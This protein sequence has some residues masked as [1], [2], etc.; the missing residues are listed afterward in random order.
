M[1]AQDKANFCNLESASVAKTGTHPKCFSNVYAY[2]MVGNV[3]E[4]VADWAP[5]ATTG[6]H[7]GVFGISGFGDDVSNMG[8]APPPPSDPSFKFYGLPGATLRGGSFAINSNSGGTGKGAG[9]YAIDQN[10]HPNSLGNQTASGFRCAT[11]FPGK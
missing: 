4:F 11:N 6:T 10:G 7:W 5:S 1:T 2:D 8:G 9:V 3:I